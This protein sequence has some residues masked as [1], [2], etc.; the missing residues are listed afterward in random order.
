MSD[1][2][3]LQS[4]VLW[5]MVQTHTPPTSGGEGGSPSTQQEGLALPSR[6]EGGTGA[7]FG[8][9][10]FSWSP[11][12]PIVQLTRLCTADPTVCWGVMTCSGGV[13]GGMLTR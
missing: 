3:N 6:Q 8:L 10:N 9:M 11:W 12:Q 5:G 13:E 2:R 7:L 4:G 1:N